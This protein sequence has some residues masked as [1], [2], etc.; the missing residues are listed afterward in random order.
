MTYTDSTAAIKFT[1][2]NK[3]LVVQKISAW[4]FIVFAITEQAVLL[5]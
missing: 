3:A 5:L 1:I 2:N 4:R